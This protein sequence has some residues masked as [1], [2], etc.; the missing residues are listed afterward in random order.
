MGMEIQLQMTCPKFFL[1][2]NSGKVVAIL[3]MQKLIV[4]TKWTK[5]L[6]KIKPVNKNVVAI[7]GYSK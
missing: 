5:L 1:W 3:L 2:I 7:G 4:K 6:F